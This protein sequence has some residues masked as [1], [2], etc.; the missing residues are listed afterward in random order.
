MLSANLC[1]EKED[2]GSMVGNRTLGTKEAI[3]G[4]SPISPSVNV[5]PRPL[6]EQAI[7]DLIVDTEAWEDKQTKDQKAEY[8]KII[9]AF[10]EAFKQEK[11]N[12]IEWK[13]FRPPGYAETYHPDFTLQSLDDTPERFTRQQ[14][15]QREKVELRSELREFLQEHE[16]SNNPDWSVSTIHQ[17]LEEKD[18]AFISVFDVSLRESSYFVTKVCRSLIDCYEISKLGNKCQV[19]EML[20]K[21]LGEN[22]SS[23]HSLKISQI[24]TNYLNGSLKDWT[25]FPYFDSLNENVKK[26]LKQSGPG[27]SWYKDRLLTHLN[28]SVSK[29]F[30]GPL[31]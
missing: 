2:T 7:L 24:W 21:E 4:K 29:I 13:S 5:K 12:N 26:L 11:N 8:E 15:E 31:I 25:E 28:D 23:D 17:L 30:I 22:P 3:K 19:V 20:Y 1:I 14:I 16:P 10:K 9:Q 18:T 27:Q 6:K